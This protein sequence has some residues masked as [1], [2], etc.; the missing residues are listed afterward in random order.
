MFIMKA[1]GAE[2][3]VAMSFS[4]FGGK[5]SNP[6]DLFRFR[7][8]KSRSISLAETDLNVYLCVVRIGL[9]CC[10]FQ[11]KSFTGCSMKRSL[12]VT[13]E[14][15]FPNPLETVFASFTALPLTKKVVFDWLLFGLVGKIFLIDFQKFSGF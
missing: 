8:F 2:I 7:F 15:N 4:G 11:T 3:T 12:F 9:C 5:L 1:T 6:D 10:S 13:V 14:K